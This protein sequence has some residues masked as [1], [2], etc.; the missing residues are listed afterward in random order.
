[1][2]PHFCHI[3]LGSNWC[4]S[5]RLH[6]ENLDSQHVYILRNPCTS[7]TEPCNNSY[8]CSALDRSWPVSVILLHSQQSFFRSIPKKKAPFVYSPVNGGNS[9][10]RSPS[11]SGG[12]SLLLSG[13]FWARICRA[14]RTHFELPRPCSMAVGTLTKNSSFHT[15]NRG[16]ELLPLP[17]SLTL[18]GVSFPWDGS[19]LSF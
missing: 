7:R 3:Y 12:N 19:V 11:Y 9:K 5:F 2:E 14:A 8:C 18:D 10:I 1:M 6:S 16:V 17:G 4:D 13:F 15:P